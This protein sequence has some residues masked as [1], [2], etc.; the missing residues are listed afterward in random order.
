MD[1]SRPPRNV[2]I[3]ILRFLETLPQEEVLLKTS[4]TEI[5]HLS[6]PS[7]QVLRRSLLAG[8]LSKGCRLLECQV[9]RILHKCLIMVPHLLR[10]GIRNRTSMLHLL[11]RV[12]APIRAVLRHKQPRT[13]IIL[14]KDSLRTNLNLPRRR[15]LKPPSSSLQSSDVTLSTNKLHLRALH[16]RVCLTSLSVGSQ[17]NHRAIHLIRNR[18]KDTLR[19]RLSSLHNHSTNSPSSHIRQ[20]K[21]ELGLTGLILPW[22]ETRRR[23]HTPN[24]RNLRNLSRW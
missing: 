10:R 18:H 20:Q 13:A 8:A 14:R 22:L 2:R 9:L 1:P 12:L 23:L 7:L 4:T 21:R 17:C 15:N 6:S 11:L 24:N 5:M 3:Y 19:T 16:L